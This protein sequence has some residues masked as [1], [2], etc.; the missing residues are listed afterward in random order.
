M[1][2]TQKSLSPTFLVSSNQGKPSEEDNQQEEQRHL[3]TLF[4]EV[5]VRLTCQSGFIIY[6]KASGVN[7]SGILE[8]RWK[9]TCCQMLTGKDGSKYMRLWRRGRAHACAARQLQDL[10]M[11]AMENG[12]E[13]KMRD[14]PHSPPAPG[15][16][17]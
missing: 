6:K 14:A 11:R 17:V 13:I 8:A 2:A 3:V 5:L 16:A 4:P 15:L 10:K 9:R 1:E 7:L 12:V